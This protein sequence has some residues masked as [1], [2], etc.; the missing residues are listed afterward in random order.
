MTDTQS[1]LKKAIRIIKIEI[2]PTEQD[3]LNE[4]LNNFLHWLEPMVDLD[5]G[6][7]E[8]ILFSHDAV[9]VLRKDDPRQG[10]LAEL[11]EAA[12]NFAGGFY[13]VPRIIE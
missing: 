10:A 2:S 8:Q 7:T 4:E 13:L 5:T 12:P 11:Q 6:G 3:E 9:N 1:G